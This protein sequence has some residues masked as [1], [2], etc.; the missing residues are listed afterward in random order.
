MRNSRGAQLYDNFGSQS[1]VRPL[2]Q[3]VYAWMTFGLMLTALVAFLVSSSPTLLDLALNPVAVIV[4][5]I[6][7]LVLVFVLS[8]AISRLSAGMAMLMFLVYAALNGFTLS[9]V[10][11]SFDIGTLTLAFVT[12]AATFAV[13]TVIGFTTS[14]DLSRYSTYFMMGLIGLVIALLVNSFL[15]SSSLDFILSILGVLLFSGLTAYDTQRIQQLAADT[16]VN[17][18]TQMSIRGALT[19][20]LDSINLFLFFLRIFDR[21][22]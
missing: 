10:F 17:S 12:T 16:D 15:Q 11:I 14:I 18:L 13:M 6:A 3:G 4:A 1:E 22:Q 20:Y 21:Q 5:V 9:L 7:E 2:M 8:G 19:L